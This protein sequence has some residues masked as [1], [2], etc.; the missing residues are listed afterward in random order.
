M[1]FFSEETHRCGGYCDI[2][3]AFFHKLSYM[4]VFWRGGGYGNVPY[5]KKLVFLTDTGQEFHKRGKV[6]NQTEF[7]RIFPDEGR[8]DKANSFGFVTADFVP[9]IIK[10]PERTGKDESWG[11]ISVMAVT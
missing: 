6:T 10:N 3:V 7:Y 9:G 2:N 4:G 11:L 5:E 8:I 1:F